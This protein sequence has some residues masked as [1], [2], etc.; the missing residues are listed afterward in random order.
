MRYVT[1]YDS[2]LGGLTDVM[3]HEDK[4]SAIEFY[5]RGARYFFPGIRIPT[6]IKTPNACGFIHRQFRIMS[7]KKFKK[8]Y[9][10]YQRDFIM[11]EKGETK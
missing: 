11:K 6:K 7:I 9:P 4:E 2:F 5:R 8:M 3:F 1:C 10:E